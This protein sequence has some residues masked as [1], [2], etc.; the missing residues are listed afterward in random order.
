MIEP[1]PNPDAA[2]G[3]WQD[4]VAPLVALALALTFLAL[5]Y[6]LGETSRGMPLLF[7]YSNL[8]FVLLDILVRTDCVLGRVLK[9]LVSPGGKP[10][11]IFGAGHKVGRE[12]GAIAW[13][14]SFSAA[15]LLL[16]MLIAIPMFA[17]LYML[18]WARFRPTKALLGAAAI[19]A[20]IWLL[21]EGVLR[22]ELYRGMLFP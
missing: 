20:G 22:V 19:S 15:I 9:P 3:D 4:Y 14:L 6:Q 5:S 12:C 11:R 17:S 16:G 21:F 2:K 7:I 1:E 18:L 10:M 8:A 13:I